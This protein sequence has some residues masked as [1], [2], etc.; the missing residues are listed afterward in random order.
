MVDKKLS[1]LVG[2]VR[3]RSD[4]VEVASSRM[5][6]DGH[7]KAEC[8]FC[9]SAG[10]IFTIDAEGQH[11][12]CSECDM[13]GDVIELLQD[14]DREPFWLVVEKLARQVGVA[15]GSLYTEEE[16]PLHEHELAKLQRGETL[17]FYE[18][19]LPEGAIDFLKDQGITHE[20]VKRFRIAYASG[21]L[22]EYLDYTRHSAESGLGAGVLVRLNAGSIRDFF[23]N[24]IIFPHLMYGQ[25]ANLTG[26]SIRGDEPK[27]LQIPD[28]IVSL[29]NE[30]A[31]R[32]PEV[33]LVES[34][35]D[36]LCAE[37]LGLPTTAL[38]GCS[39]PPEY[40]PRLSRCKTVCVCMRGDEDGT[41]AALAIGE[42]VGEKV[43]IVRLP[44]GQNL[45]E[46]L[47]KHSRDEFRECLKEAKSPLEIEI[48]LIPPSLSRRRLLW[49][50]FPLLKR[51]GQLDA[52]SAEGLL[53]CN[54]KNRFKLERSELEF[55]RKMLNDQRTRMSSQEMISG[56]MKG[57]FDTQEPKPFWE[58]VQKRYGLA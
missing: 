52:T 39:L 36:C 2:L 7:N 57:E 23:E 31:L 21:G 5:E 27:Y 24:R 15:T 4:I 35:L 17:R 53:F 37:Q 9:R 14:F 26:L 11:F 33:M 43:K 44:G 48:E 19:N 3:Y 45:V 41:E 20:T 40:I 50:L 6:L 28:P 49:Q 54:M 30:A 12:F 18:A 58:A 25:V 10:S 47:K 1:D 42:A 13:R 56:A 29:Y 22:C 8:P 16:E 32:K 34:V 46:Y 38:L 55:C 51:M